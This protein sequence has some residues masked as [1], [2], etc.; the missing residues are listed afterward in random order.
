MI[1]LGNKLNEIADRFFEN[2][3]KRPLISELLK[4]VESE[5]AKR[6]RKDS[7]SAKK[8]RE[9]KKR[10]NEEVKKELVVVRKEIKK[11]SKQ[12][13]SPAKPK[14]KLKVG[15]RV[16]MFDGRSVGSIDSIEKNKVIVNYGIFTTQINIELLE[17]VE[18]EKTIK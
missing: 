5:N 17:F 14:I 10:L 8:E 3:K 18:S 11:K 15:D 7:I 16:R 13:K 6:K 2:N 12:T 4:L 9:K 1:V